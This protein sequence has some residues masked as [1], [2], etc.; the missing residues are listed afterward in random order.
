MN[1]KKLFIASLLIAFCTGLY[2]WFF[3][4]NKQ[5]RDLQ[6]ETPVFTGTAYQ[7]QSAL[8]TAEGS[9][10]SSFIDQVVV[11]YGNI[12]DSE[13]L[14]FILN[15]TVIC[16][17]DSSVVSSPTGNNLKVKGLLTGINTDDII[18]GDLIVIEHCVPLN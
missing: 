14:S 7:L 11:V 12:V 13:N 3:V 5:H 18:Y 2:V 17:L 15:E 6:S 8:F 4:L 16:Y 9:I 1:T 10:D